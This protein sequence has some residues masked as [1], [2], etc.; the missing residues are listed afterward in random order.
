[1]TAVFYFSLCYTKVIEGLGKSSSWV[2]NSIWSSITDNMKRKA[3]NKMAP[4]INISNNKV[5][6]CMAVAK[7]Q[8]PFEKQIFLHRLLRWFL[9]TFSWPQSDTTTLDSSLCLQLQKM[10]ECAAVPKALFTTCA[11]S[12]C[13]YP[14]YA[15][16]KSG[17][18]ISHADLWMPGRFAKNCLHYILSYMDTLK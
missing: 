6:H 7:H 17:E 8:L 16:Y 15:C 3:Q 13:I 10:S 14:A 9:S 11:F 12:R 2:N 1:M 5:H 4:V 18:H